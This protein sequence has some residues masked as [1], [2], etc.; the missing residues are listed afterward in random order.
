MMKNENLPARN[1]ILDSSG[2]ALRMTKDWYRHSERSEE[3][4]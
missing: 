3:S 4:L 1:V 2:F